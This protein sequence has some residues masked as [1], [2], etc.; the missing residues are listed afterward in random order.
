LEKIY[1]GNKGLIYKF[2]RLPDLNEH[3]IEEL[4]LISA[5]GYDGKEYS[6]KGNVTL[7]R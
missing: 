6:L 2:V 5:K 4:Y 1:F 3:N 7:L